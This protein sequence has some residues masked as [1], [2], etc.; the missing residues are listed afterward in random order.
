MVPP[1]KG[2][3]ARSDL[4]DSG[5][6]LRG[7]GDNSAGFDVRLGQADHVRALLVAQ[8]VMEDEGPRL[9]GKRLNPG[10]GQ[11]LAVQAYREVG[12]LHV[13][14]RKLVRFGFARVFAF[15]RVTR[16]APARI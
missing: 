5:L 6:V 3:E 2:A 4:R 16:P 9:P 15:L 12:F 11:G 8:Y 14:V 10:A 7:V 13:L 1:K